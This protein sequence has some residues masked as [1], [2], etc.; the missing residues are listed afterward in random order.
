MREDLQETKN[1]APRLMELRLSRRST[2]RTPFPSS[3]RRASGPARAHL[4]G[5]PTPKHNS[6][7]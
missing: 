5:S 6:W 2:A 3:R 1:G 7:E 4:E